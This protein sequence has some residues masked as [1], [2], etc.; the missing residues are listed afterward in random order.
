MGFAG[1]RKR[2]IAIWKYEKN[3][4]SLSIHDPRSLINVW[5]DIEPTIEWVCL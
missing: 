3:A 1:A 4:T 2:R 5:K